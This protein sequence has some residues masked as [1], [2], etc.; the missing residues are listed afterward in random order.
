MFVNYEKVNSTDQLTDEEIKEIKVTHVMLLDDFLLFNRFM[1]KAQFKRKWAQW[2]HLYKISDVLDKVLNG[3]ITRLMIH[4]APRYGKTELAVKSLIAYCLALNPGAKFIHLSYSD[5]LA[6]DNSE[7]AKDLVTSAEYQRIFPHVQIKQSSRGKKKWYTT[8]MGGVYA[9]SSGGQITG[10]GAGQTDEAEDLG[11]DD[12]ELDKEISELEDKIIESWLGVKA[13]FGGAI[14]IDDPNKPDDADSEILRNKVNERY[15]STISNRVN[16]RKTPII[17]I[18]QR[19]HEDDLSGYLLRKQGRVEDGGVWHVLS[20][21]SIK[22]DGTALCPQKHTI[23]E[24]LALQHHND[25]VFQRQHMQNPKPKSG[26]LFPIDE[27]NYFD[28]EEMETALN[29]PEYNFLPVDPANEGGDDFAAGPFKLI[30]DRIYLTDVLYNTDGSD[31]NE[32]AVLDMIVKHLP[33]SVGVESVF[34][35]KETAIRIKEAAQE[36]GYENDFRMLRP[37]TNKHTR[38]VNRSSFIKNHFY[39]RRDW[40]QFPQ[41]AKFM[42]I[43]TS[44]LRIQEAGKGNKHDD[45][46]DLCEMAAKYYEVMFPHLWGV[47]KNK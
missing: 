17:I 8:E 3:E 24:L 4:I 12:E 23:D 6:V 37:R 29:D 18:Q 1:F 46:P 40:D 19:T 11:E 38:I 41:Y 5:T 36:K 7:A 25:I 30:G 26:L 16:S 33:S 15:D 22:E 45:A 43:L 13:K 31:M 10:F 20:L 21:P 35:W 42:R 9:T 2:E 32:I 28:F 27:L 39:F 34:G 44:Y 47:G 14:I